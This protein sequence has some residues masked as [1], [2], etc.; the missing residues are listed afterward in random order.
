MRGLTIEMALII[1]LVACTTS[2]T[3]TERSH[4]SGKTPTVAPWFQPSCPSPST[5]WG[6]E[7]RGRANSGLEVWGLILGPLP[8]QAGRSTKV[9]IR[10]T[11]TGQPVIYADGPSRAQIGPDVGPESHTGSTWHRPGD[12]W[13]TFFT[14]TAAGCWNVR[15]LRMSSRGDI[16][17]AI[18]SAPR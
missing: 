16:P 9:V 17:I 5:A 11:G 2:V 18:P 13:G 12:E 15:V 8:L 4:S 7:V 1:G 10:M 3:P 14:F 6:G